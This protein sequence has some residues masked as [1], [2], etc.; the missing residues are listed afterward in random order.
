MASLSCHPPLPVRAL[1]SPVSLSSLAGDGEGLSG[2]PHCCFIPDPHSASSLLGLRLPRR[3]LLKSA[4]WLGWRSQDE[5]WALPRRGSDIQAGGSGSLI[6]PSPWY[7]SSVMLTG[8]REALSVSLSV[9]LC[10]CG[11]SA[12]CTGCGPLTACPVCPPLHTFSLLLSSP[13]YLYC[14][15]RSVHLL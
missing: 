12:L 10:Y 15:P 2:S 14:P 5:A 1:V 6:L 3:C 9:H 13:G 11:A 8:P 4:E 7:S